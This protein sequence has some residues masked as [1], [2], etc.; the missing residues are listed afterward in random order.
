MMNENER[1]FYL[2]GNDISDPSTFMI[3]PGLRNRLIN[4]VAVIVKSASNQFSTPFK[5]IDNI[6][7]LQQKSIDYDLTKPNL[8]KEISNVASLQ[9]SNSLA[10]IDKE[11]PISNNPLAVFHEVVNLSPQSPEKKQSISK[12]GKKLGKPPKK[13]LSTSNL[14]D[15][16]KKNCVEKILKDLKLNFAQFNLKHPVDFDVDCQINETN[17]AKS[18]CTYIC[19]LCNGRAVKFVLNKDMLPIPTGIKSH[20][21]IHFNR[22]PDFISTAVTKKRR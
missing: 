16:I 18:K 8:P 12:T 9:S 17:I 13:S 4:A 21:R 15:V 6:P 7:P 11:I 1:E 22:H 5:I 10:S 19:K 3:S 20:N 2:D 14:S